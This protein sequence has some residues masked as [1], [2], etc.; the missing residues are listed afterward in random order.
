MQ[1]PIIIIDGKRYELPQLKGSAWR[2]LVA[3]DKEQ[4]IFAEDFIEKRCQFLA[5]IFGGDLT[6]D[7][8]LD[9]M[10]LEDIV[11]AY[12]DVAAYIIG[13]IT[14][15]YEDIEKNVSKDVKTDP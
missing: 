11:Q 3:A 14:A 12:R 1:R 7:I 6:A 8:L 10:P 5:D 9:N 15:R 4:D 2:K 13:R